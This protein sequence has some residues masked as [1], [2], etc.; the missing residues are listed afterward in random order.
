MDHVHLEG[1]EHGADP[2][3][4]V[5]HPATVAL[6]WMMSS[7]GGGDRVVDPV[8]GA[9]RPATAAL[10][11]IEPSQEDDSGGWRRRTAMALSVSVGDGEE[12]CG[13]RC[14]GGTLAHTGRDAL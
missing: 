10:P 1:G 7:L 9:A 2:A 14:R 13:Q 6:P 8:H 11:W 3:H 12:R 5:A 4:G